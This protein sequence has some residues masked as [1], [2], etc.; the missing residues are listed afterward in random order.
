MWVITRLETPRIEIRYIQNEIKQNLI[1]N[2]H[3]L[4]VF[5]IYKIGFHFIRLF[6]D[7]QPKPGNLLSN[8]WVLFTELD[9]ISRFFATT[10][11]KK[12]PPLHHFPH[13]FIDPTL[14]EFNVNI[15]YISPKILRNA[16]YENTKVAS[17]KLDRKQ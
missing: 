15:I 4:C 8:I 1:V 14:T 3:F 6:V 17:F 10:I 11:A 13:V 7:S 12:K 9:T 2:R 16:I 5:T